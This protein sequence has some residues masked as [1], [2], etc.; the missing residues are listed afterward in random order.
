MKRF[1]CFLL[2]FLILINVFS[3]LGSAAEGDNPEDAVTVVYMKDGK[4]TVLGNY[5][6]LS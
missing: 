6:K 2:C 5:S 4:E 1:I 3:I